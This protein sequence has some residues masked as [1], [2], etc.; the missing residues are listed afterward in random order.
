MKS[1]DNFFDVSFSQVSLVQ[2][3]NHT[4]LTEGIFF[5]TPMEI[6]IILSLI[7]FLKFYGLFELHPQETRIPSVEGVWTFSGTVHGNN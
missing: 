7:H 4:S 6:P 5:K 2:E 3:S 1:D